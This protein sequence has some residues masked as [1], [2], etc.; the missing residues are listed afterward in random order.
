VPLLESLDVLIVGAG[1]SGIGA[2]AHVKRRFPAKSFAILE[3]RDAIGGTGDLYRFSG[4]RSDSDMYTL[5]YS[6]RP[7]TNTMQSQMG[8]RSGVTS[9]IR[10]RRPASTRTSSLAL[11]SP[12]LRGRATRRSGRSRRIDAAP[13][14]PCAFA[15]GFSMFAAATSA[16]TAPTAP[17]FRMS[18]NTAA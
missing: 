4:V 14:S 18:G 5:G 8:H 9:R 11:E 2:G 17:T 6:F 10:R 1:L 7:W 12:G 15:A 16:T 13:L 3:A